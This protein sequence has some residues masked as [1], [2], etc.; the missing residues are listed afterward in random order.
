MTFTGTHNIDISGGTISKV[1]GG[2]LEKQ[3]S[4]H[5][6][7]TVSGGNVAQLFTGGDATRRLNGNAT[8]TLSGGSVDQLN[9]NNVIGSA[10]VYLTGAAVGK[11]SISYGNAEVAELAQ[12]ANRSQSTP[13]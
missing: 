5:A 10:D 13:L 9:V 11:A 7:I 3:Y 8:V 12:K 4:N 6:N 2:S 1:Y